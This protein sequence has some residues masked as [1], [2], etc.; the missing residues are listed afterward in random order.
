M[1]AAIAGHSGYSLLT[2]SYFRGMG[3]RGQENADA[4]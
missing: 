4:G 2:Q 3:K 1:P